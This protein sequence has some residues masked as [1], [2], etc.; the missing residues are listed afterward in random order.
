MLRALRLYKTELHRHP[1][2]DGGMSAGRY[3]AMFY[4]ASR[5]FQV[6]TEEAEAEAHRVTANASS[7]D[8]ADFRKGFRLTVEALLECYR[9]AA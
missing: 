6:T 3:C 1:M 2:P 4:V 9:R 7:R 5:C 8:G